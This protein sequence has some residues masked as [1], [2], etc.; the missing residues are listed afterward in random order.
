MVGGTVSWLVAHL[1]S[2]RKETE[3]AV[4]GK[5]VS[6]GTLPRPLHPVHLWVPLHPV[7]P[8]G[9]STSGPASRFLP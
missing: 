2:V 3:Q 6:S 7:P 9:S 5:P 8:P 1:G 4:M